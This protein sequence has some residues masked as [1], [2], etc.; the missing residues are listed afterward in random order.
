MKYIPIFISTSKS[1]T[2]A[3]HVMKKFHEQEKGNKIISWE[4]DSSRFNILTT[5]LMS[6]STPS[7]KSGFAKN[8]R[9]KCATLLNYSIDGAGKRI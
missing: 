9:R 7:G 4:I 6:L 8:E 5:L 3:I 2:P 1:A